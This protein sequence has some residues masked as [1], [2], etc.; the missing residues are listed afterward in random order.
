[1]KTSKLLALLTCLFVTSCG[2]NIESTTIEENSSTSFV[3][4]ENTSSSLNDSSST[5]IE[6]STTTT[7]EED[8]YCVNEKADLNKLNL[9][10][11]LTPSTGDVNL[12]LIPIEFKDVDV[13]LEKAVLEKAFNS[14]N[15]VDVEWYSVREYYK[16]SSYGNLNLSFDILDSFVPAN[17]SSYY[18]RM[19]YIKASADLACE[20]LS[21]YE[22]S[23]DYSKY[24]SNN[25][26]YIDGIQFIYNKPVDKTGRANLWWAYTYYFDKED[27]TFDSLK[28]KGYVLSGYDFLKDNNQQYNTH[29]Y[30]H[31]TAHLFGIDDYYDYYPTAGATKGGL[32]GGDMMDNTI[33]D[34][35]AFTKALLGWNEG[36]VIKTSKQSITIELKAFS[37]SGDYLILSNDFNENKGVLQEYFIVEYYTPTHLN[38]MDKIFNING[39]RVLHI[40]A[41]TKK[42][43]SFKYDNSVSGVKLISQITTSSGGTY[44]TSKTER[45]DDTLFVEGESLN[46]LKTSKDEKIKY[47]FTVDK[48]T[49]EYATITI[50]L[51]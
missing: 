12:L 18:E 29:T 10:E 50:S 14:E 45:S 22:N 39:I 41:D 8:Y 48:L 49:E 13:K 3:E 36:K 1:M 28:I 32:A 33:G 35:N 30:I 44:L 23:I 2:N 42:D 24:D 11:G 51:K 4:S 21:Y 27:I 25:D 9:T 26:G 34:H 16:L 5:N 43:G 20:A 46:S 47:S 7:I 31:E 15:D 17:N 37:I 40:V 19:D 38:E 6:S